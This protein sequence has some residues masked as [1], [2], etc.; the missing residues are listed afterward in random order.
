[1]GRSKAT[2]GMGFRDFNS[3]NKALLAK[4]IWRLWENPSSLVAQIMQAKYYPTTSALEAN[5]GR[6]ISFAWRSIL[7]SR[8]LVKE[9]LVWRVGNGRKVRIWEDRW[10]PSPAFKILTTPSIL[11]PTATVDQLIDREARWWDNNQLNSLFSAEEVS[12]IQK[13]SI[14]CTN[15][16]DILIWRGTKNGIFSVRSAYYMQMEMVSRN[17]GACSENEKQNRIWKR[18]WSLSVPNSE[19]NFLWRA[20]NDILPTKENLCKRKII[21][22][23]L[24]MFCGM[25][26]ESGLHILWQC[27]ST[28]DVRSGGCPKFQK[29]SSAGHDFLEVVEGLFDKCTKEE[30][31]LF[32]STVRCIWMRRN[33]V[34]HGGTFAHPTIL[35]QRPMQAVEDFRRAQERNGLVRLIREIPPAMGWK[36][37]DTGWHKANWD[38][39]VGEKLGR[40]GLGVV[41]RDSHGDLLSARCATKQGS[42]EP[43]LAEAEAMLLSIQLCQELNISRVI[44]EGDAK[45]V[46]EG[47]N[48]TEV[49]RGWMGHVFADIKQELQTLGDWKVQ[50][51]RRD[52]NKAAHLLAKSAVQ[53]NLNQT[54]SN[55]PPV[56]L[57]E[58][59]TLEY[60]ALVS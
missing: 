36:P 45:G 25:E 55:M 13:I 23:P 4:Q 58:V 2:G 29:C 9:G 7:S 1:M 35:L 24:C 10:L 40:T 12:M 56:C 41:I 59:L 21:M 38:A 33:E 16:E 22:D 14:S 28:M 27:P 39:A 47:I 52:D 32:C 57:Q 26:V 44:F 18:I 19:K 31:E 34:L 5:M 17:E 30:M 50:F 60:L 42:L 54:W 6:R 43:S 37:P 46:V 11:N 51:I 8:E 15:Q 49:D 53:S 3:F 20:C 48:S